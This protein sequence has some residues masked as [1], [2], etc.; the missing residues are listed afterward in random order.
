MKYFIA[1]II[2]AIVLVTMV[3][4]YEGSQ[5][6]IKLLDDKVQSMNEFNSSLKDSVQTLKHTIDTLN[7]MFDASK[8][9]DLVALSKYLS[10]SVFPIHVYLVIEGSEEVEQED[11]NGYVY[12]ETSILVDTVLAFGTTF[13][14]GQS[15]VFLTNYHVFPPNTVDAFI[16]DNEGRF[17][18]VTYV[19]A[20]NKD[21]DYVLFTCPDLWVSPLPIARYLPEQGADIFTMGNPLNFNYTLSRGIVSGWLANHSYIQSDIPINRGSSGGPLVNKNGEVVGVAFAKLESAEN[22]SFGINI[23]HIAEDI[24]AVIESNTFLHSNF[25]ENSFKLVSDAE[26][27]QFLRQ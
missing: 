16:E 26:F 4:Y 10:A 6:Q 1:F 2:T 24:I 19:I 12:T 7:N 8:P 15:G 23:H 5:S 3:N 22:F 27:L 25:D 9:V 21:L 11:E 14:F 18:P 17:H 13:C 20:A